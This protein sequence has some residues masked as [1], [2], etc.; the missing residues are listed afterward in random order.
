MYLRNL[1]RI[2]KQCLANRPWRAAGGQ[3]FA[4]SSTSPVFDWS[5][6]LMSN[7]LLTE[8]ELAI[9]DTAERYCQ[10]HLLPRVL[11]MLL[12]PQRPLA[13]ATCALHTFVLLRRLANASATRF[14]RHIAT[15][16]MTRGFCKRW[17]SWVS[18]VRRLTGTVVQACRPWQAASSLAQWRGL[19]ADTAREC[20]FNPP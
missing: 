17:E 6:P 8:E 11:R 3:R 16:T 7:A 19:T 1:T 18:W 9:A 4:S 20:R 15:S 12:S 13:L 10:G 5:D 14:Q 2:P